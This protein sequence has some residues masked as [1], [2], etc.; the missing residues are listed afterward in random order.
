MWLKVFEKAIAS[1]FPAKKLT[2]VLSNQFENCPHVTFG[3]NSFFGK[4]SRAFLILRRK[5]W[6]RLSEIHFTS[7]EKH[8]VAKIFEK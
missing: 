7:F 4:T 5:T 6:M 2:K 3:Q 8:F 1:R